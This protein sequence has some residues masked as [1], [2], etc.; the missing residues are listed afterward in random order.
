MP[1]TTITN[2]N[3]IIVIAFFMIFALFLID[4]ARQPKKL[5]RYFLIFSINQ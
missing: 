2:I 3:S 4:L 5:P 1:I